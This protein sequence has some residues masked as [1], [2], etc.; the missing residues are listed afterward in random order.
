MSQKQERTHNGALHHAENRRIG[1]PG[2]L[3]M[4]QSLDTLHDLHRDP[5]C[6]W[7]R[8]TCRQRCFDMS[9]H[10]KLAS[11]IS[12]PATLTHI[13]H[14]RRVWMLMT[15]TLNPKTQKHTSQERVSGRAP[16]HGR[17]DKLLQG[18]WLC[19]DLC[20]GVRVQGLTRALALEFWKASCLTIRF[21]EFCCHS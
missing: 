2:M 9:A 8:V 10:P 18:L 7:C 6:P 4:T 12:N 3:P 17:A 13:H 1:C 11:E 19:H 21:V 20:K 16:S 14:S 15:A 5:S